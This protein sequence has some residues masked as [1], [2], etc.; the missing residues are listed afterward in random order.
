MEKPIFITGSEKKREEVNSILSKF[1]L[2][3]MELD[4]EEVQSLD[5]Y[6]I[7]RDKA[8]RAYKKLGQPVVIEDVAFYIEE[9]NKFPGPLIKWMLVTIKDKGIY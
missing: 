2:E 6:E 7:A 5:V 8:R 9:L 3:N 4:L 1:S